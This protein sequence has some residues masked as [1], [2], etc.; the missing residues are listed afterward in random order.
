MS[1]FAKGVDLRLEFLKPNW[2][3]GKKVLDI[4]CNSALLTVFIALHY[5]PL[6]I[7][8]VDI[9]PSLIGKAQTFVLKTFSQ[10]SPQ[11]YTQSRSEKPSKK[12]KEKKK[13]HDN[14]ANNNNSN[15]DDRGDVKY[16]AY[17][18]KALHRIHGFLPVPEATTITKT[19]F[20]HNIEFRI[21]D[22]VTEHDNQEANS[23]QW[24]VIL[25]FSLTKWIH[26]HHGDDGLKKFFQKVYNSLSPGGIFLLESQAFDTYNRRSKITKE[27]ESIYKSIEFRPDQFKDYLLSN[28]G[29][30][31]ECILLGHSEGQAKN[32]NRDIYLYRK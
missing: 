8:G 12:K 32:F 13:R 1:E 28:H 10:L 4:G 30:F 14:D 18:P 7:Q 24:D 15:D 27:M 23:S 26:L 9:D 6:K 22:W 19:L 5:K 16:E 17:F 31:K 11:S 3:Q 25:G 2:F 21:V 29:G 20:P